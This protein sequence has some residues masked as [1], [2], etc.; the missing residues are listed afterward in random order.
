MTKPGKPARVAVPRS[1]RVRGS[2]PHLRTINK[3]VAP[4]KYTW[5]H[6]L[7]E[8]D[9]AKCGTLRIMAKF[10]DTRE[11][12]VRERFAA[13]RAEKGLCAMKQTTLFEKPSRDES[14]APPRPLARSPGGK[15]SAGAG[16]SSSP[17]VRAKRS[18]SKPTPAQVKISP[19]RRTRD[20]SNVKR[21]I[22]CWS[23]ASPP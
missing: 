13:I 21:A 12:E 1:I 14:A 20:G 3:H 22:L 2:A 10:V 4:G 18:Q 15:S 19:K 17:A 11:R 8:D 16:S 7:V 9:L 5:I 6:Q 23:P